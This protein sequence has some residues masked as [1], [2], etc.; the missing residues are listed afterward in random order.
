LKAATPSDI[1]KFYDKNLYDNFRLDCFPR[2]EKIGCMKWA[3]L[4]LS[5][6]SQYG[7]IDGWI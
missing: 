1:K 3:D 7:L 6:V 2:D 4:K 5:N